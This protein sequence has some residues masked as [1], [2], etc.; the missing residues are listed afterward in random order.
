MSL[1]GRPA[2]HAALA[3][4]VLL[5]GAG[6]CLAQ[7]ASGILQGKVTDT[8]GSPVA[9]AVVQARSLATGVVRVATSDAAG[10]YRLE[11]LSPGSWIVMAQLSDGRSSAP[12]EASIH[13][14][15]VLTLD[16]LLEA[17]LTERVRV[18]APP[19]EVNLSRSGGELH[20][21]AEEVD[22]LPIAGRVATNLALLDSAVQATPPGNFYGERG[23]VFVVNGQSGR[24]N[25]FLVDGVDNNDRT[26]GTTLN[27]AFSQQVIG[28][29]VFLTNQY[30]PEFGRASGGIMNIVTQRGTNEFKAGGF[31]QGSFASLNSPGELVSGLPNPQAQ[32]ETGHG[33]Q[34]GFHFGG[35]FR[36]DQAFYYTAFEH[37]S[38]DDVVPYTGVDQNGVAG[39]WALTPNRNDSL[40][41]RTDFNLSDATFLMVRLSGNQSVVNNVNVGG[42]TTPQAGFHLEE[43]DLQLA[44]SLT[45]VASPDLLNE[46][47]VLLSHSTFAQRANS[48]VSGVER[49]SGIFGGN[50]LHTQDR[51]ESL[52]QLV[53]NLTWRRGLH[54]AK[55]GIDLSRSITDVGTTFN[56]DGNFLYNTDAPFEPGDCGGVF[57]NQV[58]R[59]CSLDPST[60]CVDDDDCTGKGFCRYDPIDCPGQ[61]GVDDD[62]DG[63]IDEPNQLET[64]PTVFTLI[65][66][67]PAARLDD[68]RLALFA[69]DTWQ[70]HPK[71][72]L[73]YGL[74]YDLSTFRLPASASVQSS[75]PNGG[76]PIDKGN[77]APRL[78]FTWTPLPGGRLVVRGG[79][80][81]F[82]DK[83]V[84]GFPA[85][86]AITS[87]TRI[88]LLFPQGLTLEFTEDTVAELGMETIR[89]ELFFPESLTLRFSTGTT[90]DTPYVNQFNLG[91][92]WA[93][94]EHG[95]IE[96]GAVRVLGY[97]QAL[98]R[99]LNPVIGRTAQGVPEHADGTVGSIA[100]IVTEGRSWYWGMDLAWRW[101]SEALR[102][103]ASYTLSRAEDLG[104]DPLK[105]GVS[106]PPDSDDIA[107]ERSRS[108][109]DRRHRFVF[110]GQA[111]LPWWDLNASAV[112]QV[113]SG[114]AFNVTTGRDENLD[115][116]TNDRPK[117]V[118]RNSGASTD[119]DAVNA[120]RAAA[121]LPPVTHLD[122]PVFFQ[123]DLRIAKPFL[124]SKGSGGEAFVQ[125][126]NLMDRYNPGPIEGRA[127][128]SHFGEAIGQVGP[129]RTIE[130]GVRL[131]F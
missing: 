40:F 128:S 56:F 41:L 127:V 129:P 76:A 32:S 95:S 113:A 120:V 94:G 3:T 7:T 57:A 66:G 15:E 82:Y 79:A 106:L 107:G 25:S 10:R 90:L 59:H 85:V 91:A 48:E 123:V 8:S 72:T 1:P 18:G 16:L 61:I 22:S 108:D 89:P 112:L 93:V 43:D 74:R 130:L 28:E 44:A 49:P 118:P 73:N 96:A 54:T 88:G 4:I 38:S 14:Q 46:E 68:T 99:D 33:G 13:L 63:Q 114:T 11:L 105:G 17:S 87:G 62:G 126:F 119:L 71:L 86:A 78:G 122:E 21:G 100:A 117:G 36:P 27:S 42:I 111:L 24:S 19:P 39:G 31:I 124:S 70:A 30:A 97:H 45:I 98:M 67:E 23:S 12:N 75:I 34:A 64:Y 29:F 37:Q 103:A 52:I 109:A 77:I 2:A 20:I 110:S 55:F 131:D 92:E 102:Y 47:R 81:M 53:D 84:L 58:S 60:S 6:L 115:G 104:P 125:V 83:L 101:R 5:L 51:E 65:E 116:F 50:N 121:L 80:G 26:S 35:A 69:Q 9:K